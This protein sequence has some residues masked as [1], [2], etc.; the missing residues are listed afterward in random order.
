[1][2]ASELEGIERLTPRIK[3]FYLM[4]RNYTLAL[5]ELASEFASEVGHFSF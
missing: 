1:M 3:T 5:L 4:N 2:H